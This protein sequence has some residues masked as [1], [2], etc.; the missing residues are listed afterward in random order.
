ME[1]SGWA[2]PGSYDQVVIRGDAGKREFIAFWLREGRV[3]AGMNVNVWDVTEPLQQLI[4][5]GAQLDAEAVSRT[6]TV[7][8]A[9]LGSLTCR[10]PRPGLAGPEGKRSGQT[11]RVRPGP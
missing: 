5:S 11:R 10:G 9:T 1:Y 4:R 8:L 3:L 2:P 6:R 7:D